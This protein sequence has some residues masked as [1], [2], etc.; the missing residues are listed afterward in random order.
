[1]EYSA[2]DSAPKP[3]PPRASDAHA[4]TLSFRARRL[5]ALGVVLV[6]AAFAVPRFLTHTPYQRL[7]V[8]LDWNTPEGL[9][10]VADV[11]GP[12]GKGLLLKGDLLLEVDGKALTRE[13]L[14]ATARKGGWPRGP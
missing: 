9:P 2:R 7:G 1:M 3:A 13:S 11:V 10:R 8:R 12:P 4:M 5:L 6:A 14:I